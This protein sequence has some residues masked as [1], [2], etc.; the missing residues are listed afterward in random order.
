[1]R[2]EAE[3]TADQV[4]DAVKALNEALEEALAIGLT[5]RIGVWAGKTEY[6]SV[7]ASNKLTVREIYRT[8]IL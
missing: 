4:R 5:V 2:T 1:M 6:G 7:G 3:Y 8:E